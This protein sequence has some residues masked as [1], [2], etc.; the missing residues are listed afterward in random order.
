MC[1]GEIH[2]VVAELL[3]LVPHVLQAGPSLET[4]EIVHGRAGMLLNP[5][6]MNSFYESTLRLTSLIRSSITR[7]LTAPVI[8][9]WSSTT[10]LRPVTP[11]INHETTNT[12]HR[13]IVSQFATKNITERN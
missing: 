12:C 5:T 7:M 9:P 3:D 8:I 11:K 13:D 4:V 10:G 1:C 6:T 2:Q